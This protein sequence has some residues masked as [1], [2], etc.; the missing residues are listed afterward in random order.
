[1][2]RNPNFLNTFCKYSVIITLSL[3]IQFQFGC[4]L[5]KSVTSSNSSVNSSTATNSTSSGESEN[6]GNGISAICRNAYYPVGPAVE[7]KYHIDYVKN[8]FPSQD[9]TERYTDFNGDAFVAKT[10]F[11]AVSTTINWRCLPDGLLATQ[12][13]NSIDIKSGGGAKIDTLDSKGVSFIAETR[14]NPGEK[15]ATTYNIKETIKGPD[16]Q[17]PNGEGS[18]TV[19]QSGE[20]IEAEQVTV[21]AGTFQTMKVKVKTTLDLT[22]KVSGMSI[23]TK[24]NIDTTAWFAKDVGMVKSETGLGGLGV[25]T[26]E[27]LSYTGTK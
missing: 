5:I 23:P 4:S 14:W 7:R 24:T 9:Y 25:A 17:T 8:S 12:Y 13:G 27:L 1:M 18:G 15:W 10:D 21:P 22:V 3:L 11:K 6:A 26:T 16:G 2:K 19:N 20:V